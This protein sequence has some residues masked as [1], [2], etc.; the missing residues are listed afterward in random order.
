MERTEK[1][2][3]D[4]LAQLM[5]G[6]ELEMT[7]SPQHL[8]D[9]EFTLLSLLV[10]QMKDRYP[11]Q[12]LSGSI[13]GYLADYEQLV[14]RYSMG[15]V[16]FALGEWRLTPGAEFFPRPDEIAER[17]EY[18]R[19]VLR[20]DAAVVQ[21]AQRRNQQVVEFWQ[22]APEWMERTGNGETEL[23]RRFPSYQGTKPSEEV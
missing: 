15:E 5:K 10:K 2:N 13:E 17:I 9:E 8:P 12:D 7:R 3:E 16:Q 6:S 11:H 20:R 18:V 14:L 22:W 23:L 1:L 19:D 21:A 4:Q